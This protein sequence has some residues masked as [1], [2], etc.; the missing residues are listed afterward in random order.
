MGLSY[1]TYKFIII[2]LLL[3]ICG[4]F[5]TKA[6]AA[7]ARVDTGLQSTD[8]TIFRTVNE[9]TCHPQNPLLHE[10][11][12]YLM[13]DADKRFP[14]QPLVQGACWAYHNEGATNFLTRGTGKSGLP[15]SEDGSKIRPP[16]PMH[17]YTVMEFPNPRYNPAKEENCKNGVYKTG[18]ESFCGKYLH[19]EGYVFLFQIAISSPSH[20]VWYLGKEGAPIAGKNVSSKERVGSIEVQMPEGNNRTYTLYA[21]KVLETNLAGIE[22]KTCD[23]AKTF[24]RLDDQGKPCVSRKLSMPDLKVPNASGVLDWKKVFANPLLF[25]DIPH[26]RFT[27]NYRNREGIRNGWNPNGRPEGVYEWYN[28]P[29]DPADNIDDRWVKCKERY[30]ELF[31]GRYQGYDDYISKFKAYIDSMRITDGVPT[32]NVAVSGYTPGGC[33]YAPLTGDPGARPDSE[34]ELS[35]LLNSWN[36]E[37]AGLPIINTIPYIPAPPD[38]ALLDLNNDRKADLYDYGI[39]MSQVGTTGNLTGDVDNDADVDTD[40]VEMWVESFLGYKP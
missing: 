8:L 5:T 11:P 32:V 28:D 33:D 29:N 3:V 1:T 9:L 37:G 15:G 23:E 18:P 13:Y 30:S 39:L 22:W 38:L 31:G 16:I 36:T 6:D 24:R 35:A 4:L 7:G 40:D 21:G 25:K 19:Y 34:E 27:R 12:K 26:N 17:H 14:D 2:S 10:I 20:E